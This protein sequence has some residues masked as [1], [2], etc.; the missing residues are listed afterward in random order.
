M[1][2]AVATLALCSSARAFLA[3]PR[4][5]ASSRS[6]PGHAIFAREGDNDGVTG[7][8]GGAVLGGLLA[9]P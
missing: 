1:R 5:R 8:V 2:L 7:A 4:V 9:G 3:A 6:I